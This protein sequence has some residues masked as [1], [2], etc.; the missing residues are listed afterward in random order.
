MAESLDN[1]NTSFY[2]EESLSSSKPLGL[3]NPLVPSA[4]LGQSFLSPQFLSPVAREPLVN[5]Q[6]L[7]LKPREA[8]EGLISESNP[9]IESGAIAPQSAMPQALA[10][11]ATATA[12][13]PISDTS[14]FE[15]ASSSLLQA[16]PQEES[17]TTSPESVAN[18]A[19]LAT[20]SVTE[21]LIQASPQQDAT[22][23]TPV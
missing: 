10:S 15:T 5:Q 3:Q 14:I 19:V 23:I 6:L 18:S 9:L 20:S 8:N 7:Q 4:P 22:L 2:G 11:Q 1:S 21:S 16:F 17:A 12:S 13:S